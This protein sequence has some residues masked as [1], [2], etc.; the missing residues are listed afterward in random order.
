MKATL[1]HHFIVIKTG[2]Q[3]DWNGEPR[4]LV[5]VVCVTCREVM[6]RSTPIADRR[7]R[8]HVRYN[9]YGRTWGPRHAYDKRTRAR[10]QYIM[11]ES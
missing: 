5:R 6:E 4:D 10:E 7:I 3:R 2:E 8:D 1:E 11:E 9:T